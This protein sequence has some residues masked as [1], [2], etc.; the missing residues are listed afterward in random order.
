[1]QEINDVGVCAVLHK[2]LLFYLYG[3][4][5]YIHSVK[6]LDDYLLLKRE[7]DTST[8]RFWV[9]TQYCDTV[10]IVR[11]YKQILCKNF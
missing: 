2:L 11:I 1:M 7:H 3:Y 5:L 10:S 6:I 4:P 9:V 8:V